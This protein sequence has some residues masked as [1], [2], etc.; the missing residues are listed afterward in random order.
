MKDNF[1][2]STKRPRS[3]QDAVEIATLEKLLDDKTLYI[4]VVLA[5]QDRLRWLRENTVESIPALLPPTLTVRPL[6][7]G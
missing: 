2:N 5:A 7:V 6:A 1:L 3:N 4:G